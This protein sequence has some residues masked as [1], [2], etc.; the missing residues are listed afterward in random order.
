M[1][2]TAIASAVIIQAFTLVPLAIMKRL[3]FDRTTRHNIIHLWIY[4]HFSPLGSLASA[5]SA[6]ASAILAA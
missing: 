1:W 6:A 3:P 5:F 4:D 2:E